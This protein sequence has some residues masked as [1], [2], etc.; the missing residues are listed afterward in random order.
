MLFCFVGQGHDQ[1]H[2]G[3][4]RDPDHD[5]RT[6]TVAIRRIDIDIRFCL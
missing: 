2:R 1:G 4:A 6:D 5:P 3:E